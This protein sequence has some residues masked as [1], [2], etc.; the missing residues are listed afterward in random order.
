M[1]NPPQR[2]DILTLQETL[3]AMERLGRPVEYREGYRAGFSGKETIL[4][5][6]RW[7]DEEH[8]LYKRGLKAGQDARAR[9][10]HSEVGR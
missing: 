5:S 2:S 10:A 9:G 4:F 6:S 3:D 1:R 8:R 7:T